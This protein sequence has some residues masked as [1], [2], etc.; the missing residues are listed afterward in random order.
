MKHIKNSPKPQN[1]SRY[2]RIDNKT[3]IETLHSELTDEEVRASFL[4]RILASRPWV[5]SNESN[6]YQVDM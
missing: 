5:R 1:G 3:V 4:A 6:Y 2:V